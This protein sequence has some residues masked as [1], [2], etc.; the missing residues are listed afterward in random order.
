MTNTQST[1]RTTRAA[2]TR[3]AERV[4]FEPTVPLRGRPLSRRVHSATLAPLH[5][6]SVFKSEGEAEALLLAPTKSGASLQ[7][8]SGIFNLFYRARST[9][10]SWGSLQARSMN[11]WQADLDGKSF[12][13][14]CIARSEVE[15]CVYMDFDSAS[16]FEAALYIIQ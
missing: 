14:Q 9:V 12:Q 8:G 5:W 10:R 7:G 2:F 4:G 15:L 1:T 13:N 3:M 16:I 11:G 6:H